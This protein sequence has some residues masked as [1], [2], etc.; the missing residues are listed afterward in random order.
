MFT[1]ILLINF[2]ASTPKNAKL[3]WISFMDGLQRILLITNSP[4]IA[5][6]A[7]QVQKREKIDFSFAL[8]IEEIGISLV[9]A[10]TRTEIAYITFL[11]SDTVWQYLKNG[12]VNLDFAF[13]ILNVD[14]AILFIT[15]NIT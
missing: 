5:R 8:S 9:D 15:Y 3:F 14:V 7:K 6:H 1:V 12:R 2:L 4:I 10:I 11:S 13:F